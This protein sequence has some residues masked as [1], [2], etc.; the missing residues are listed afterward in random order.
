[1]NSSKA[2]IRRPKPVYFRN[3]S[4][5]RWWFEKNHHRETELWVGYYKKGTGKPGITWPESVDEALCFGWIDG[6][7]KSIDEKRYCIR[8]TP[9]RPGSNWSEINIERVSALR[10]LGLMRPSGEAAF[11]RK[12]ARKTRTASYEQKSVVL[13]EDYA[14]LFRANKIAWSNFNAHPPGYR[15]TAIWWVISAKREETRRKRLDILIRDSEEGQRIKP[16]RRPAG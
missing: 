11:A 16:L 7:R 10:K 1:M 3:Q 5:L 4:E 9:R 8:F 2:S 6:I 15:R 13:P 14:K 12:D